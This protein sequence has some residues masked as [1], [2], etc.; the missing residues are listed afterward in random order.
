MSDNLHSCPSKEFS[1]N[2]KNNMSPSSTFQLI[3]YTSALQLSYKTIH[4]CNLVS[5]H[6]L[7]QK[8]EL[9]LH[10]QIKLYI[11]STFLH[12]YDKRKYTFNP[13]F[14]IYL[15]TLTILQTLMP[16]TFFSYAFMISNAEFANLFPV[17]NFKHS[18]TIYYYLSSYSKPNKTVFLSKV[19]KKK[20]HTY[21]KKKYYIFVLPMLITVF[22]QI[23]LL[24]PSLQHTSIYH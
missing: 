19:V 17:V 12:R 18:F 14:I 2:N 13:F 6:N 1:F 21:S 20:R 4:S 9:F 16:P 10:L 15:H 23:T 22:L 3:N 24:L 11:C 7:A 5:F 8:S